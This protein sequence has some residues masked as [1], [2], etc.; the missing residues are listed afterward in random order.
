MALID[1]L[2][3]F[4][5]SIKLNDNG[6]HDW[7]AGKSSNGYGKFWLEGKWLSSHRVSYM[8]YKG[9]IQSDLQIDHLCRN[10]ACC[11]PDHLEAVTSKE[12]TMRG[13]TIASMNIKKTHCPQG[14]EYNKTNTYTDKTNSRHCR[15]CNRIRMKLV[16]TF[17]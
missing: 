3:R 15:V 11:N 12:N 17:P 9:K 8:L 5:S 7:D 2:T 10:R 1:F 6:C 14:H 4:H 13:N 16:R